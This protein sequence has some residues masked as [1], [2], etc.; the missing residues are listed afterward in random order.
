MIIINDAIGVVG[1]N[2]RMGHE[3]FLSSAIEGHPT[4][5]PLSLLVPKFISIL[6]LNLDAT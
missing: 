3:V 4:P 6:S 2:K 5:S 1:E